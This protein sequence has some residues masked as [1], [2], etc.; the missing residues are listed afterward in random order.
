MEIP[1]LEN[2]RPPAHAESGQ[3]L[4]AAVELTIAEAD[5]VAGGIN[6]QPLP[7]HHEED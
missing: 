6:P 2:V 1:F 4:T 3:A 5:G 7:P